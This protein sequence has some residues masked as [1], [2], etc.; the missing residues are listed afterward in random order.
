[1]VL[2][3][4]TCWAGAVIDNHGRH[5]SAAWSSISIALCRRRGLRIRLA[6]E[7]A[8]DKPTDHEKDYEND[9]QRKSGIAAACP[10]GRVHVSQDV[11]PENGAPRRRKREKTRRGAQP[12]VR[13]HRL[14]LLNAKIKCTFLFFFSKF[15][16]SG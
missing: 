14:W 7:C 15:H 1:M 5:S 10:A 3:R 11:S 9:Y 13:P 16:P 6:V 8:P 12:M 4:H 2:H